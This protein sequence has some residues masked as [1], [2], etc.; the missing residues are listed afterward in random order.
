MAARLAVW[1]SQCGLLSSTA[2]TVC[3]SLIPNE[4]AAPPTAHTYF[5]LNRSLLSLAQPHSDPLD[6]LAAVASIDAAL[7]PLV[8]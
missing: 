6:W 7:P 2:P 5:L 8:R 1:R 4:P 3:G